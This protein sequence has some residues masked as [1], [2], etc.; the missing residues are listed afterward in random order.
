MTSATELEKDV[1]DVIRR[2]LRVESRS[3]YAPTRFVDDLGVDSLAVAE[4]TVVLEEA[5]GVEF[6]DEDA[7]RIRTVRDAV[8]A[9]EDQL[10]LRARKARES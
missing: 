8:S 7:A 9:V 6:S 4:L 3:L 5:F 1:V 10:R 2:H